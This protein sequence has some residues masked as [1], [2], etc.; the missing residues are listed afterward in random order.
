MD[1][2]REKLI[3]DMDT[4]SSDGQTPLALAAADGSVEAVDVGR[5][6]LAHGADAAFIAPD[7]LS[8]MAIEAK[9]GTFS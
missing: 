3:T 4:V 8:A 7:Q 2:R 6:L 5:A 1:F 9:K